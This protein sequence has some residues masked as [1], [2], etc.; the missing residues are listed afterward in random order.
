MWQIGVHINILPAAH[1]CPLS[2]SFCTHTYTLTCNE[3]DDNKYH[4]GAHT[5]TQFAPNAPISHAAHAFRQCAGTQ[6]RRAICNLIRLHSTYHPAASHGGRRAVGHMCTGLQLCCVHHIA[7]IP[8]STCP[9]SPGAA[10]V[11]VSVVGDAGDAD[12]DVDDAEQI[13]SNL[14]VY[15][16]T[17]RTCMPAR[18][19]A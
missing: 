10:A 8:L 18:L 6:T 14:N 2:F 16:A 5:R 17:M 15:T 1:I 12:N 19:L 7:C 3:A 13:F 4:M 11:A 9:L